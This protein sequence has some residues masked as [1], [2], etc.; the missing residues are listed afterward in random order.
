M[1]D[2]RPRPR[3]EGEATVLIEEGAQATRTEQV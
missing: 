2:G 1:V 3:I